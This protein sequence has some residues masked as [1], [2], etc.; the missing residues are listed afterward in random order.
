MPDQH[1]YAATVVGRFA[2]SPSGLLH[3]GSLIAAIGSYLSARSQNGRWLLRI[4]DVDGDRVRPGAAEQILHQLEKLELDWDGPVYYQSQRSDF[5]QSALE[6]LITDHHVYPCGCSRQEI[7]QQGHYYPG[8]CR[9]GLPRGR[10]ARSWRLRIPDPLPIWEDRFYGQ[11]PPPSRQGDP[12]LRRADGYYAY[13]L[14]S[15]LDDGAQGVTEIIRGGDLRDFSGIQRH[16]QTL[17]ELPHPDYGHLPLLCHPDGRKLSKSTE[18]PAWAGDPGRAWEETLQ[19][20]GWHIPQAL[21]G[22]PALEWRAWAL[23][24]NHA[25][26][27]WQV[28]PPDIK[29]PQ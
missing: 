4:E 26:Q 24:K 10:I 5:Y 6:H 3:A 22:A 20:L 21:R 15:V 17:L 12:V 29:L 16:L 19:I 9:R 8:T 7:R 11:Q 1:T 23:T 27:F 28:P 2:P 13:L 25:A 14:A 18:S